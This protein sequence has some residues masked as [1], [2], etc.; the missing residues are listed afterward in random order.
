MRIKSVSASFVAAACGAMVLSALAAPAAHADERFGD[1]D[2]TGVVVAGGDPVVLG[3]G[4]RTVTVEV[5]ATDPAGLQEIDATLYHGSFSAQDAAI[6]SDAACG[7]AAAATTTCTLTFTLTPGTAPADDA[8]AGTW[9]VGA[10]AIAADGDAAFL[11]SAASFDLRRETLLTADA[12]PEKVRWGRTVTVTGEVRH[13][14]WAAG[15]PV[16]AAAGQEVR[17]QFR[18]KGGSAY[19]TVKTVTTAADGTVS[20]NVRAFQDGSY[21]WSYA[22][23]S[24][25]AAAVS[26]AD[27]V[28]VRFP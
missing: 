18:A 27:C 23:T 6:A 26:P 2:I 13:A 16:A 1:T 9:S 21:R 3:T 17:L 14:G 15:A 7:P 11:D 4:P 5:T 28:D 25:T 24:G 8:L 22:G 12:A 19:R 10:Y 20:A